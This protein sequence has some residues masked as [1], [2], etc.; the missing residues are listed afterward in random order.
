MRIIHLLFILLISTA[1]VL[2]GTIYKVKVNTSL[3]IR[4]AANTNS[5]IVGSLKNGQLLYATSVSNGWA[6][7]YKGYVS[8]TYLTKITTGTA[9]KAKAEIKCRTG[10]ANSYSVIATLKKNASVT[11]FG[12][13][14]FTS[15][16]AITNK[17]YTLFN[18]LNKPAAP[19]TPKPVNNNSV[20][21][22]VTSLLVFEEGTNPK[23]VCV[24]YI[25]SLGYPTVGYGQLCK[26][27]KVSTLAQAKTA[28]A[29]Y[30]KNCSDA[31]ARQWLSDEVDSKTKCINNYAVIKN[32]YN[33]AS[34]KRKAIIISMAYQMGCAGLAQFTTTLGHMAKGNWSN[35]S[36]SMMDSLWARQTPNRAKRHAYVIKNNN[37]GKDFCS[38]YGW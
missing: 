20:K 6:K 27:S 29:S 4:K 32:A 24:P 38:N 11:Y 17:G 5:A 9:Y 1:Y 13:D 22:L 14:P 37:C 12:K 19:V 23:G 26:A 16:W 35:A 36:T 30:T 10:P 2:A 15:T 21:K 34:N 33:K 7:F 3:N 18:N 25:D 31:K 28:C 8:T